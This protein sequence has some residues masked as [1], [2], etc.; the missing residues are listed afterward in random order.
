M[1][2]FEDVLFVFSSI[3][4]TLVRPRV[5]KTFSCIYDLSMNIGACENMKKNDEGLLPRT[6]M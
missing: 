1:A 2:K 6:A 5:Y 3:Y 4:G